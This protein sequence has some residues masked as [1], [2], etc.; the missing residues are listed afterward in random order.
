MDIQLDTGPVI[1]SPSLDSTIA[2]NEVESL[3]ACCVCGDLDPI[4]LGPCP[5]GNKTSEYISIV[6]CQETKDNCHICALLWT[7]SAPYQHLIVPHKTSA[8][9][10]TVKFWLNSKDWLCISVYEPSKGLLNLEV[11]TPTGMSNII[12][13][14]K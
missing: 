1:P 7:I 5:L 10:G 12:S 4:Y 2:C 13:L 14:V 3:P 9:V 8:E 6:D 11:F